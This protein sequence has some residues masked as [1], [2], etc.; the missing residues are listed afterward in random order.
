MSERA[1]RIPHPAILGELRQRHHAVIE[2]S[3]GTGKTFTLEHLFIDLL[4][5]SEGHAPLPIDQI[6]LVTFT[7]KAVQE[8]QGRCRALL[9]RLVTLGA[10]P[11][12]EGGSDDTDE[13]CWSLGPAELDRLRQALLHFDT[14]NISTIHAFC[15]RVLAEEAFQRG[16]LFHEEVVDAN[17]LFERV[18]LHCLRREFT[19]GT[20]R[21]ALELWL[22]EGNA[23]VE[24]PS[25]FGAK[26]PSLD[27]LLREVVKQGGLPTQSKQMLRARLQH[28]LAE[29]ISS[30]LD[31]LKAALSHAIDPLSL[32]LIGKQFFYLRDLLIPMTD[33]ALSAPDFAWFN[34]YFY[35]SAF[36]RDDDASIEERFDRFG[37]P[38]APERLVA[39][40]DLALLRSL[41]AQAPS[42]SLG[43]FVQC[44][45]QGTFACAASELTPP[46]LAALDA[47][48]RAAGLMDFDDMLTRLDV[49][50]GDPLRGPALAEHLRGRYRC[51]LIDEF[52]DTDEIQWRIFQKLI[53]AP[54]DPIPERDPR[55][56]LIGDPKQS[57]YRFRGADL[58]TYE[59]ARSAIG[60]SAGEPL[61]LTSNFRTSPHLI[62]AF[63]VLFDPAATASGF[64]CERIGKC[65]A[66]RIATLEDPRSLDGTIERSIGWERL[67][68]DG[69]D[70]TCRRETRD[71]FERAPD[72]FRFLN[73]AAYGAPGVRAG[74]DR[75]CAEFHQKRAAPLCLFE[76]DLTPDGKKQPDLFKALGRLIA[77]EIERLHDPARGFTFDTGK[78]PTSARRPLSYGD[79]FVL[80]RDRHAAL[81]GITTALDERGIPYTF[82]DK[83][84]FETREAL[85]L[86]DLL[87]AIEAPTEI[88][89]IHRAALSPFFGHAPDDLA[90]AAAS[91]IDSPVTRQL[92]AWNRMAEERHY[93]RL[94]ASLLDESAILG[95]QVFGACERQSANLGHLVELLTNEI[96]SRPLALG[97]VI[98]LLE[99]LI[100]NRRALST[101]ESEKLRVLSRPSLGFEA[102]GEAVAGDAVQ[103]L[104]MHAAKGLEAPVVFVMDNVK[105]S[106]EKFVRRPARRG[107]P[108]SLYL[109]NLDVPDA[110]RT[111]DTDDQALR[112]ELELEKAADAERLLYV[113][114]TRAMVRLYLPVLTPHSA[115][116]GSGY[117]RLN[118]R[119]SALETESCATQA[120]LPTDAAKPT[121][122]ALETRL[123]RLFG[124]LTKLAEVSEGIGDLPPLPE[125]SRPRA[126]VQTSYSQMAHTAGA[127][128]HFE[129][130]RGA[131]EES[132]ARQAERDDDE[133]EDLGLP[134]EGLLPPGRA[135][136][137]LVHALLEH[138]PFHL[139]LE[140]RTDEALLGVD[141]FA[142]LLDRK[143]R[144]CGLTL[145]EAQQRHAA[146][147]VRAALMTPLDFGGLAPNLCLA[148]LPTPP[149][150]E[151][152]FLFPIPETSHPPLGAPD[153][154]ARFEVGRGF[155]KGFIDLA[156]EHGDRVW[157][158]DWKTDRLQ[159]ARPDIIARHVE[160]NYRV[161][162]QLY[163]LA[164]VRL[165]GATERERFERQIGGFF[166]LFARVM[167]GTPMRGVHLVRPTFEDVVRW[168]K[169][170][171]D[172]RFEPISARRSP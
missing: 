137:N 11:S 158:G 88:G 121:P 24:Q 143:A 7:K 92:L 101:P 147:L 20:C 69:L 27:K 102:A 56:V 77:L 57:I 1:V 15:E 4:L 111:S 62:Q 126:L 165:L 64:E 152:E 94:F 18:F 130:D 146:R 127:R 53:G 6:L 30:E 45:P 21:W 13:P 157:L 33:E 52:Q 140:A 35:R 68:I 87:R 104:T 44:L 70:G 83:G 89:L 129:V 34:R 65:D 59:D 86:L 150:H 171:L 96:G 100:G 118:A 66:M 51:V 95:R 29:Q 60:K 49:A 80:V 167:D 109:G 26:K 172:A 112:E 14:A 40:P 134:S 107:V 164:L 136:G 37:W 144:A 156:F 67:P 132:G 43:R 2:A 90:R 73:H 139:A 19:L 81:E 47:T 170:L 97:E 120:A 163:T 38:H 17:E 153:E 32:D 125:G 50:L 82:Q 61:R 85:E 116:L 25:M 135:S 151:M 58:P 72:D 123:P 48:K 99:D 9:E 23:I 128:R 103:I 169:E 75:V 133:T 3:A 36:G 28:G 93:A 168:E 5:G 110:K 142:R 106:S 114:M 160:A 159:D 54:D 119:L 76:L 141:T 74:N 113:A 91:P 117:A 105:P 22:S 55:L 162:I 149:V 79:V 145:S 10:R 84:I 122:A 16:A 71:G 155:V 39:L 131:A 98:A 161:Q 154:R 12:S 124:A 42:A 108:R 148:Q 63:N 138:L 46:L 31:A 8:L 78:S 41:Q 115:V 166:Y